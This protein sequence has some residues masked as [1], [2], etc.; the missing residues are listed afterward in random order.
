MKERLQEEVEYNKRFA[1]GIQIQ[2]FHRLRN[3]FIKKESFNMEFSPTT[4]I[5]HG[6][7]GQLTYSESEFFQEALG[8]V[9]SDD[10]F[11]NHLKFIKGI[12]FS[13]TGFDQFGDVE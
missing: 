6:G 5:D 4:E 10:R 2:Y 9:M 3:G 11:C 12:C 8:A 1:T 7:E 13:V